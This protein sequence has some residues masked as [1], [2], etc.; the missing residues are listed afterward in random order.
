VLGL[1]LAGGSAALAML[2]VVPG[3]PQAILP[4]CFI[5]GFFAMGSV[6][7]AITFCSIVFP[8]DLRM[9]AIATMTVV[10]RLGGLIAP[11]A[12]GLILASGG[13]GAQLFATASGVAAIGAL[14]MLLSGAVGRLRAERPRAQD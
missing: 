5:V 1:M 12:A 9:E 14:T 11:V 6:P 2:P 3:V 13:T 4:M 10:S 7:G 8:N